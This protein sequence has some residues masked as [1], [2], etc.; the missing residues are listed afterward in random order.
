[1]AALLPKPTAT[2]TTHQQQEVAAG[3]EASG[4]ELD[5]SALPVANS[6]IPACDSSA[7]VAA[8]G[9]LLMQNY[10][11]EQVAVT[12]AAL[13]SMSRPYELLESPRGSR[14][15]AAGARKNKVGEQQQQGPR[16]GDA[17]VLVMP[18]SPSAAAGDDGGAEG[19]SNGSTASAV[20]RMLSGQLKEAGVPAAAGHGAGEAAGFGLA[21]EQVLAEQVKALIKDKSLSPEEKAAAVASL[22]RKNSNNQGEH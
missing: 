22:F 3:A 15:G 5:R 18:P 1:V 17:V 9:L 19:Q 6:P 11:G 14:L 16:Q 12:K 10:L 2:A 8:D 13:E 20:A 7:S 4:G 21:N